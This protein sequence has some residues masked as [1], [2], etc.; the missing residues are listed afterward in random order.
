MINGNETT[1]DYYNELTDY[2]L[3]E[4]EHTEKDENT[5]KSLIR[6]CS[7]FEG[8][9]ITKNSIVLPNLRKP[10]ESVSIKFSNIHFSL[11][12]I[13][14]IILTTTSENIS[15]IME[16][17]TRLLQFVLRLFN[18]IQG[19]IIEKIDENMTLV[20]KAIYML[21]YDEHGV[22]LEKIK[23]YCKKYELT[24]TEVEE[25]ITHLEDLK[26]IELVCGEYRLIE[27]IIFQVPFD[28]VS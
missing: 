16:Q 17:K 5:L 24:D 25:N 22:S 9:G 6:S 10:K 26:C 19:K 15:E 7:E 8:T 20:L 14:E 27:A 4:I 18:L 23:E 21:S 12:L 28:E 11:E 13:L 1:V 3:K 2:L